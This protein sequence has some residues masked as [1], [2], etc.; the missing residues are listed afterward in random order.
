M[1][2]AHNDMSTYVAHNTPIVGATFTRPAPHRPRP[3]SWLGRL[4]FALLQR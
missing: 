3:L 4:M 2:Q 1:N